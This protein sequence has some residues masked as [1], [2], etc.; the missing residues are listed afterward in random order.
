MWVI[1]SVI[2]KNVIH[3]GLYRLDISAHDH[4]AAHVYEHMLIRTF[5]TLVKKKGF[6]PYI[7]GW[8]TGEAFQ[9]VV[10][11]EYGFYD[12]E[13]EALLHEYMTQPGKIDMAHFDIEVAS[14]EAEDKEIISFDRDRL[15]SELETIDKLAWTRVEGDQA[16]IET[17]GASG[18]WGDGTITHTEA[19]KAFRDITVAAGLEHPTR[20]EL[21]AYQRINPL[22]CDLIG[23]VTAGLGYYTLESS[24]AKYRDDKDALLTFGIYSMKRDSYDKTSLIEALE[25]ARKRLLASDIDRALELYKAAF[26]NTPNWSSMPIEYF[27]NAGVL[28]S[29]EQIADAMTEETFRSVIERLRFEA[30]PTTKAH[31]EYL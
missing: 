11:I 12:P 9:H 2:M 24:M 26:V 22:V 31:R 21:I 7:L 28:A 10:F 17:L 25:D 16:P 8:L 3:T 4:T 6:N 20:D 13:V 14:I 30:L 5:H 29:R 18:T 1:L 15:V 19:K 23:G 27:R